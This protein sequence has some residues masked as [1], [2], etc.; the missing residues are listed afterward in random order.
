MCA[1]YILTATAQL[2]VCVGLVLSGCSEPPE[3]SKRVMFCKTVVEYVAYNPAD[4]SYVS[5]KEPDLLEGVWVDIEIDD[6]NKYGAKQRRRVNCEFGEADLM[7]EVTVDGE[8]LIP[9]LVR[10]LNLDAILKGLKKFKEKVQ[11]QQ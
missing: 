2:I 11:N 9:E 5:V 10:N 3:D 6:F 1:T 7:T 8:F 4:M